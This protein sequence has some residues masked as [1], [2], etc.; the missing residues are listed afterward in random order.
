MGDEKVGAREILKYI[1]WRKKDCLK[2]GA[3]FTLLEDGQIVMGHVVS[4]DH[5]RVKVLTEK[6][7]RTH[8]LN[9]IVPVDNYNQNMTCHLCNEAGFVKC[10]FCGLHF[11]VHKGRG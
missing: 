5:N 7:E 6:G 1:K 3:K 10:G 11:C 9:Y 8:F 2:V 4:F